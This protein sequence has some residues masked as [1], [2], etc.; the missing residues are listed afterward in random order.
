MIQSVVNKCG[1]TQSKVKS[2]NVVLPNRL[3]SASNCVEYIKKNNARRNGLFGNSD[4]D[5]IYSLS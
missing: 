2:I 4:V 1:I 3:T 5:N